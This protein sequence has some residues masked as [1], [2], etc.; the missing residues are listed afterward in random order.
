MK[1]LLVLFLVLTSCGGEET[2]TTE[3]P[4]STTEQSTTTSI[5]KIIV[6]P[7]VIFL[8]CPST[9]ISNENYEL[10]FQVDSGSGNII[11]IGIFEQKNGEN[12]KNVFFDKEYNENIFTFP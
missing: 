4:T 8:N 11:N 6:E 9:N 10:K 12:N 5:S 2:S 1:K 3:Q 7:K